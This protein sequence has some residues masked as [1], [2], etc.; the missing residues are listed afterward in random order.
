MRK[1]T[2]PG[3]VLQEEFLEPMGLTQSKLAAHI[4]VD[5]KTVNRLVNGGALSDD[6]ASK[7]SRCFET[8]VGFWMN[9]QNSVNVYNAEMKKRE[10]NTG[11][12]PIAI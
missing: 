10:D 3:E 6:M 8:S 11:I 7:L 9:L 4:G 1:P 2:H 12:G 5:V